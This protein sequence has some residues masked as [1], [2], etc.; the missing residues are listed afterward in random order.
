AL[1]GA[2]GSWIA[3]AVGPAIMRWVLG[4]LFIAMGIWA[5]IPDTL[6]DDK[7]RDAGTAIEI[8]GVTTVA[9]FLAEIGDKTQ[10]ATAALA[11]RFVTIVPVVLGTTLGMLAADVPAVLF[12]QFA[13]EHLRGA[14]VRYVAAALFIVLGLVTILALDVPAID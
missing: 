1:A 10:I 11:A 4:L 13:S 8:F 9:F 6:D 14:W 3:G 12:G 7:P 5:L 2:L